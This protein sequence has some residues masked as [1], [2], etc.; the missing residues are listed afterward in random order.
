M[1]FDLL[2]LVFLIAGS[3]GSA[4]FLVRAAVIYYGD[5]MA[6]DPTVWAS[7][8]AL[9]ACISMFVLYLLQSW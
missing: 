4:F 8:T 6:K 5:H 1:L 7:A 9:S 3:F 2:T